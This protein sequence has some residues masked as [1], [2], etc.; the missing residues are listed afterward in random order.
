MYEGYPS[1]FLVLIPVNLSRRSQY[2]R[3]SYQVFQCIRLLIRLVQVTPFRGLQ[4]WPISFQPLVSRPTYNLI[5]IMLYSSILF[6]STLTFPALVRGSSSV[7]IPHNDWS[8]PCFDGVCTWNLPVATS[9][10]NA[11][12]SGRMKIVS[13]S[14]VNATIVL[15][16]LFL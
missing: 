10:R 11:G 8:K 15:N 2:I 7:S 13:I 5:L 16:L 12:S 3:P 6:A 9:G 14:H 1:L 4:C